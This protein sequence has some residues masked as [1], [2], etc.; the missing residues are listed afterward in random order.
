[1]TKPKPN[2]KLADVPTADIIAELEARG[3]L[4]PKGK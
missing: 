2:P 3:V 1:M 4:K